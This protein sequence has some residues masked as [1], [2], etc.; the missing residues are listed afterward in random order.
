MH[1]FRS[2]CQICLISPVDLIP[3]LASQLY[4]FIPVTQVYDGHGCH[5]NDISTELTSN[6]S[7]KVNRNI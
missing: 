3:N 4:M 2:T 6:D 7:Q 1:F 5:D